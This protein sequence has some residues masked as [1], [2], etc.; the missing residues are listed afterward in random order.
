MNRVAYYV[1][2]IVMISWGCGGVPDAPTSPLQPPDAVTE[3]ATVSGWV[4]GR[5]FTD[6]PI[7]NALVEV[8]EASGAEHTA[9]TDDQGFYELTARAGPISITASKEGYE[10]KA[11]EFSL[12]KDTV[13]NFGLAQQ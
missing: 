1:A 12:L 7:A 8:K 9:L 2:V 6:P 13:L 3:F 5:A 11:W 10:A 4:Y